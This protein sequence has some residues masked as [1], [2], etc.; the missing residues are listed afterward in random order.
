[1]SKTGTLLPVEVKISTVMAVSLILRSSQLARIK[2]G[3]DRAANG[4]SDFF[5]NEFTV[6]DI[7]DIAGNESI[8]WPAVIKLIQSYQLNPV[9]VRNAP[10]SMLGAIRAA[11]LSIDDMPAPRDLGQQMSDSAL[12]EESVVVAIESAE[13][14]TGPMI[15]DRPVR[16]GQRIYARGRDLIVTQAVNNGA[17]II[18]DGSIH[19]YAPLKGRALA[20][21]AGNTKARIFASSLA[22]ELVSIAGVYRNFADGVP[23]EYVNNQVQCRLRGSHLDIDP[24]FE[25]VRN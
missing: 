15:V 9:A 21:A 1:M 16:A 11:G 14:D 18:A 7:A 13:D 6:I 22:A 2:A 12:A 3:L 23:R 24:I 25:R 8:D 17:E 5:D 19:V 20:G 4:A 10:R